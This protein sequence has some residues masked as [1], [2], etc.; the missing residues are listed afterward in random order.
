MTNISVKDRKF[1]EEA[2]RESLN[3]THYKAKMG[4]ILVKNG[5]IISKGFNKMRHTSNV[6]S[7]W[8]N[9]LHAEVDCLLKAINKGISVKNSTIY[10]YRESKKGLPA[11][12]KPCD[13]CYNM[14]TELKLKKI[15]Y[16]SSSF[17]WILKEKI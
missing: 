10:I 15:V 5:N 6:N 2:R 14:I 4:C 17:P 16:T 8:N 12:S 3:S 11:L 9:S 7:K 13:Y 1:L